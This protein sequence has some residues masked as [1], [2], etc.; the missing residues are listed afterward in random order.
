MLACE[1]LA[2]ALSGFG[3]IQPLTPRTGGII[4]NMFSFVVDPARL[5]DPTTTGREFD[6][7]IGYLKSTPAMPGGRVTIA[8]EPE[9]QTR[10]IRVKNGIE[11]PEATIADLE[12]AA[13][14]AGLEKN[15][16]NVLFSPRI[17]S[18]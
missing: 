14:L 4:N 9:A 8:G 5:A 15:S 18:L 6:E 13:F 3:T 16:I 1:M 10:A 11:L 2:G 7:L 17:S 12:N